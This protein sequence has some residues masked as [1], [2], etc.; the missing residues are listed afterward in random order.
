MRSDN[1]TVLKSAPASPLL[2][3]TLHDIEMG[4]LTRVGVPEVYVISENKFDFTEGWQKLSYALNTTANPLISSDM[5]KDKWR[6]LYDFM[7][8]FTNGTGFN[9]SGDPRRDYVNMRDLNAPYPKF[10][11]TRICGGALVT[12]TVDGDYLILESLNVN[13]P[14][15]SLS[16]L[17]ARPWLFFDAVNVTANGI[18]RFPQGSNG[19]RVFVPL[20]T[21]TVER[22]PL[23]KLKKLPAG[24]DVAT[25]DA[26]RVG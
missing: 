8:A 14:A 19:N 21:K 25:H 11:K 15:P 9:E 20:L 1:V 24:Y 4:P 5:D 16:W 3:R 17:L 22:Y 26:Y 18:S 2:W 12:G 13:N 10:D 7:R 23:A 6:V